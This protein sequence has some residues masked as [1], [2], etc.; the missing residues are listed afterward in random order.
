[1]ENILTL[2]IL[3][4]PD[5]RDTGI[6]SFPSFW[7]KNLN[8]KICCEH[9][10]SWIVQTS[11][12]Y[13]SLSISCGAVRLH[14]AKMGTV[15]K[16]DHRS[17]A[18]PCG[19]GTHRYLLHFLCDAPSYREGSKGGKELPTFIYSLHQVGIHYYVV[20]NNI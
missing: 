10:S 7:P 8:L 16:L 3:F 15:T 1:M 12:Y 18:T 11:C 4:T 20:S 13:Y 19:N 14:E 17:V 2:K 6:S 9:K 5:S